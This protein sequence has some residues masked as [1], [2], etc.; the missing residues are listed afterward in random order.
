[1]RLHGAVENDKL[2]LEM[3]IEIEYEDFIEGQITRY[4]KEAEEERREKEEK[5]QQLILERQKILDSAKEMKKYGIDS[6]IITRTSGL[7][8]DEIEKL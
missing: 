5:E 8:K 2:K 6:K 4:K 1:R 3:E 7:T